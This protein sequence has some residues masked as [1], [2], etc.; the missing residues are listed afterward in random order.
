M[1]SASKRKKKYIYIVVIVLIIAIYMMTQVGNVIDILEFSNETEFTF[2]YTL[3]SSF[4]KNKT[5]ELSD[6]EF[7]AI[8]EELSELKYYK[9]RKYKLNTDVNNITAFINPKGIFRYYF[10]L[11][12]G[13]RKY[14]FSIIKKGILITDST[15]ITYYEVNED[16]MKLIFE[17]IHVM[18]ESEF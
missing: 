18:I 7:R 3:V 10:N 1:N 4:Q 11:S 8:Y 2:T 9:V 13:E 14:D 6:D 16:E 15:G 17:K 12:D 5:I